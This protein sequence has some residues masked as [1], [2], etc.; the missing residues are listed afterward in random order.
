MNPSFSDKDLK[1]LK[2]KKDQFSIYL[3]KIFYLLMKKY[4]DDVDK[5][6]WIEELY[7]KFIKNIND[8]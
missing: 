6:K 7:E 5:R 3:N 8:E 4:K 1:K 2:S